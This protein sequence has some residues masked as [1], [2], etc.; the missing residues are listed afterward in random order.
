LGIYF[1]QTHRVAEQF[2]LTI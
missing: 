1:A 2:A